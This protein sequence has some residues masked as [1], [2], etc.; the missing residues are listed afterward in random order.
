MTNLFFSIENAIRTLHY[1]YG[2]GDLE[3]IQRF[4]D[5]RIVIRSRCYS[6]KP[7]IRQGR[8]VQKPG[9]KQTIYL[10]GHQLTVRTV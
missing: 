2:R 9:N 4:A 7:H 3:Y 8:I 6:C 10:Y 1:H 5:G